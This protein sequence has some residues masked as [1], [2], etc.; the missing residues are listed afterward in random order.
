VAFVED[1]ANLGEEQVIFVN[2]TSKT[3]TF[4]ISDPIVARLGLDYTC[5]KLGE[6]GHIFVNLTFDLNDLDLCQIRSISG[7]PGVKSTSVCKIW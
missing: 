7:T 4:A 2:L 3:L 1:G 5:A 6:D